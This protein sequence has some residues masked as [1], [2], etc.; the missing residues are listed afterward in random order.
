M[1][2]T[3]LAATLALFAAG[4]G[5]AAASTYCDVPAAE[6]QPAEALQQK[7]EGE[8]WQVKGIKTEEGCYEVYAVDDNGK[9]VEALFDPKTFDLVKSDAD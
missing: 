5:T 1:H 2:R 6:W 3:I 7:L 8:G 4:T 9:R